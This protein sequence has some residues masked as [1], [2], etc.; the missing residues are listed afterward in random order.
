MKIINYIKQNSSNYKDNI[1]VYSPD[2]D[3]II[4]L[5]MLDHKITLLRYDQQKSKLDGNFNGKLY[6]ILDVNNFSNILL[7]HIKSKV[8]YFTFEKR[9]ISNGLY[10]FNFYKKHKLIASEKIIFN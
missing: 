9:N 8:K 1:I 6:N 10:Y 2:S 3:M 5:M 4:L 7:E